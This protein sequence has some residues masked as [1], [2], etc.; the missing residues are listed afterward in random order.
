MKKLERLE[1]VHP[2]EI[3]PTEPEFTQWL[4]QPENL[5]QLGEEVGIDLALIEVEAAVGDFSADILAKDLAND[6]KIIIENQFGS[7]NHD[8][9]GKIITYASGHTANRVIWIFENIREEHR[10]AIDWLN[11]N[12]DDDLSFFAVELEV[13]R[14][15]NSD[16]APRFNIVCRPNDW[17]KTI[18]Q[19]GTT[20]EMTGGQQQQ[21]EFWT[22]LRDHNREKQLNVRLQAP[23]PQHWTNVS[24]GTSLAHVALTMHRPDERLGCELYI[25]DEK[26]LFQYLMS[27][28][29]E[30]ERELG[31]E[32]EWREAKKA[33]RILQYRFGFDIEKPQGYP[34]HFDWLLERATTFRKVFGA[35]VMKYQQQ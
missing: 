8:H 3:W 28:K 9:L 18:K 23:A 26:D 1:P 27:N 32:L 13:W 4:A 15:A 31:T 30:I 29:D 25:N 11:D 24:I 17:A 16:P 5:L 22:A 34:A 12:T 7:T 21:F 10:Q 14:I 19:R 35:W 6:E 2:R 33:C 20:G